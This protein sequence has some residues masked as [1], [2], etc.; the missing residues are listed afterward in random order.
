MICGTAIL[1]CKTKGATIWDAGVKCLS[2]M[3]KATEVMT[4]FGSCWWEH[5]GYFWTKW[6]INNRLMVLSFHTILAAV[7]YSMLEF[8]RKQDLILGRITM[9]A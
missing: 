5:H 9:W 6:P 4:K 1:I 3:H 2:Y 7:L 8:S